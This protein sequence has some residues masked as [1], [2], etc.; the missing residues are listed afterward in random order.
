MKEETYYC[1]V[2]DDT[3]PETTMGRVVNATGK[4]IL[5]IMED[6]PKAVRRVFDE[7]EVDD[8]ITKRWVNKVDT[9]KTFKKLID[10]SYKGKY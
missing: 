6:T 10:L 8:H 1:G 7:L 5:I 9:N 3:L 4:L 2:T